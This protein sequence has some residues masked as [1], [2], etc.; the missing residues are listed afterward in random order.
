MARYSNKRSFYRRVWEWRPVSGTKAQ[1]RSRLHENR[2]KYLAFL[3]DTALDVRSSQR[4]TVLPSSVNLS[5]N[6]H[7]PI[8][9]LVN[10]K[11]TA[12]HLRQSPSI[13][14]QPTSS[15]QDRSQRGPG[16]SV[17]VTVCCRSG[18][19]DLETECDPSTNKQRGLHCLQPVCIFD[20]D[21][22]LSK[23]TVS[24]RLS[25]QTFKQTEIQTGCK[26]CNP[27]C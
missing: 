11:T 8:I 18:G 2:S 26:Q 16:Q 27:L 1:Q 10:L 24:I 20:H 6:F 23:F 19:R 5:S 3:T 25:Q 22:S 13:T 12:G 4:Q 9:I 17:Y 21:F 14:K 7:P 15:C